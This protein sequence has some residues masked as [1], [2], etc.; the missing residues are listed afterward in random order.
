MC[1]VKKELR[2]FLALQCGQAGQNPLGIVFSCIE[3]LFYA[4]FLACVF[5]TL[6]KAFFSSIL[7][8][9]FG[10]TWKE[11]PALRMKLRGFMQK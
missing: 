11:K 10:F 8:P 1:L 3:F 7:K 6:N 9:C 2:S 5:A 4:E